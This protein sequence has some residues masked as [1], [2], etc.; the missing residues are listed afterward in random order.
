M[1][2]VQLLQDI[3]EVFKSKRAEKLFSADLVEALIAYDDRPWAECSNGRPMSTNLLAKHLKRF[4]I[5]PKLFRIGENTKRG[6]KHAWFVDP[7][8]RYVVK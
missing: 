5:Q 1:L 8:N 6:Y 4:D 2:S 7:L 3:N